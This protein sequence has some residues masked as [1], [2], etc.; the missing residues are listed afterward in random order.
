MESLDWK[1]YT[2]SFTKDD[3]YGNWR[4]IQRRQDDMY[5][6]LSSI[7]TLLTEDRLK[8]VN[9]KDIAYKGFNLARERTHNRCIC[10]K[11]LRYKQ[12]NISSPGILLDQPS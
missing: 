1:E 6:Q 2:S 4:L 11:G 3:S 7:V 9:L 8:Q 5:L 10:C 12:A